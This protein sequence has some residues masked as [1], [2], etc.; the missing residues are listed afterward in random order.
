VKN[1]LKLDMTTNCSFKYLLQTSPNFYK[2]FL[3]F[4]SIK[5]CTRII[6]N[7]KYNM[8]MEINKLVPT[9]I[10]QIHSN[11]DKNPIKYNYKNEYIFIPSLFIYFSV[12]LISKTSLLM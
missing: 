7:F 5:V 11:F 6:S 3:H 4:Y 8:K 1:I 9:K 2:E 10:V 12:F